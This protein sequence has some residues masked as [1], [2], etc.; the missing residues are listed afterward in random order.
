MKFEGIYTPAVTPLDREGN[1][2]RKAYADVLEYLI[3]SRVHGVIVGGSTGNTMRSQRK[4]ASSWRPSPKR[5]SAPV[6]R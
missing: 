2:D 5:F 6:C 3:E 1:I 4:N